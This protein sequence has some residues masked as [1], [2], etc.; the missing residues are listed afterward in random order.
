[1]S[2]INGVDNFLLALRQHW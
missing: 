1:V 2:Q